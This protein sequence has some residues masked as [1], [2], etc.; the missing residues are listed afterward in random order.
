MEYLVIKPKNGLHKFEISLW[1]LYFFT[2]VH[3]FSIW[4]CLKI[5]NTPKP[6]GFADHYPYEKWLFHWE[7]NGIYPTFSDKPISSNCPPSIVSSGSPLPR[8]P[9]W[10]WSWTASAWMGGRWR[11]GASRRRRTVRTRHAEVWEILGDLKSLR[12][13]KVSGFEWYI[14]DGWMDGWMD[15]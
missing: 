10:L 12:T 15:G 4:V 6:N 3:S 11:C 2:H 1:G 13:T 14:I 7:Y 8:P 9:R 5:G